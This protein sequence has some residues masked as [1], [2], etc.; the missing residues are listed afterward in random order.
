MFG[1][2]NKIDRLV[3][4]QARLAVKRQRID[5]SWKA[6]NANLGNKIQKLESKTVLIKQDAENRIAEIDRQIKKNKEQ[7]KL[8][9]DYYNDTGT[10]ATICKLGR[11][12]GG[13]K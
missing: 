4:Q 5:D 8:E 10:E 7:I 12:E 9:K 6:K 3:R 11:T 2:E 13:R 1:F